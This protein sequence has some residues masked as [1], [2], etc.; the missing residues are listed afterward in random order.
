[1]IS[2]F[3]DESTD[4]NNALTCG[5]RMARI[6]SDGMPMTLKVCCARFPE[7]LKWEMCDPFVVT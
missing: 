5:K 4:Y 2:F 3:V 7:K 1:M 6:A